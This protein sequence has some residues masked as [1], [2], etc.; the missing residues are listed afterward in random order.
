MQPTEGHPDDEAF[1]GEGP[2]INSAN[3]ELASNGLGVAE[4]KAAIIDWL[5]EQGPRRGDG[6]LQAARLAVQPAALL[7]RAVPDRLR[8]GRRRP[9]R[10][11]VDAARRAA[12]GARLPPEDLR[13]RGRAAASPSRRWRGSHEWV[14][15]ELDLGDGRGVQRYRRETNTMPNWA[16]SCWYYLRYLD[17]ANRD[18]LVDP[19]T[20]AVLDGPAREA[21]AGAP[22]GTRDP[23]G[24]DLYVGGVEHAVLHLLYARFWHKVLFDLGHVVERGAVP[25]LLQ[26]GLHPGR[27]L[28][29]TPAASTSRPSEVEEVA[30][31]TATGLHLEGQP[32]T[33]EFGKI[34]KSLKNMVSPGRDVRRVRRRHASALYEMGLGP[35]EQSKPWDTRAV[36]GSQRFLQ[37]LWRNVVDEETGEVRRRRRPDGRRDRAA[38]CTAPSTRCARD[39]DGLRFNT[40]IARLIE[41]NNA[42]TK[43]RRRRRARPPSRSSSWSRRWPRTSPRSCGRG[44]GTRSR[45]CTPPSRSPTRRCSSRTTVTCVVQVKGKVRDRLEVPA[46]ITEDDLP[47]WP[48]PAPRCRRRCRTASAR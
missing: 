25:H 15:V 46:D 40:A 45:W 42:L 32:V 3:D 8:R 16:G 24:V 4:A 26:P 14:N 41:L 1:T 9:R 48:W 29:A 47:S 23:G 43:L 2:A 38:C 10:A 37:R 27:R 13:P 6:H 44:W 5:E 35:L 34:G 21:V 22:A 28:H 39:Y 31:A 33:R 11:R 7:G 12:R 17:P 36:V 19:E 20:E 18:A 30:G